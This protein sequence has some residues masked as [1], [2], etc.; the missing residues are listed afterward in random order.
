MAQNRTVMI[1][2]VV[3]TGFAAVSGAAPAPKKKNAKAAPKKALVGPAPLAPADQLRAFNTLSLRR[4]IEDLSATFGGRYPKGAEYLERLAQLEA[5]RTHLLGGQAL[6]TASVLLDAAGQQRVAE[7]LH[8]LETLK[9]EALLSNPLLDFERLLLVKR[10]PKTQQEIQSSQAADKRLWAASGMGR[11]I[12]LPTNHEC[13][14]SIERDGYDNEIAVLSPVRPDGRLTTLYRPADGGYVGEMDLH[15]NADRLLFTQS[16]FTNWKVW[17]I[18]TDGTGLRQVSQAPDDVDCFDACYLPNGKIVFG[19]T[20]SYQAVPCWH[21]LRRVTNLYLMNDDGT[22]MRQICFDQDHNFHPTVMENGQVLYHRWD[23]TGISHIY[24]RQLMVMNPDGMGQRAIYGSNSWY[25]NS[26]YFPKPLPGQPGKILCI[27]SGYHGAHRMGQL[28]I[29]DTR[30]GWYE[31]DGIVQRISGRGDPIN[32][33]VHDILVDQDWPKFLTPYPL[34]DK[35]FLVSCWTDP[36]ADWAIYL[37]D[38]FDNLVPLRVEP[39]YALLE[40]VPVRKTQ[41]PPVIPDK[42]DLSRKDGIVYLHN[43][44]AGPGL[45]GVP[46]GTIKSIRLLAYDFGYPGLAGPDLIGCAGPWEVMRILGTVPLEEDGSAVFRVPANTPVAVQALDAQGRAVQLMRSWYTA[47]PGETISCTGCHESPAESASTQRSLASLRKPRDITPWYGPVRGFD[48]AREVQPVLDR[49]CVACHD[50]REAKPDLRPEEAVP[51]YRGRRLSDLGVQRMHPKMMEA[52]SGV[53]RYTPAYEALIPYIRRVSI[54][55]DVSLL[56]PGEYY[57]RTS[58]LIQLLEKGHAGVRLDAEAWDRLYTWIDLNAPCHG[59]WGEVFPIPD[60]V[61]ARR[62]ELRKLYGGPEDDPE[63]IPNIPRPPVEPLKPPP[64]PAPE[65]VHL[66][67][68]PMTSEIALRR[69]AALGET[70]MTLDLGGG[71]TLRLVQIPPGEFVMGDPEGEPDE[72]PLRRVV[73]AEPFW[74]GTC[75]ITNE[76]FRLFDPS[77]DSRYYQKRHADADDRGL[78][79][80]GPKQPAV[81]VSWNDAMAFCRW[82]SEK[83]GRTFTLPTE[84]QW[85]YACRAGSATPLF[86]GGLDDDFSSWANVGDKAFT[87]RLQPGERQI[88]GGLEH[89]VLEGADLADRR[90][91]DGAI[92]TAP[93][94][95]YR[96]NVW[97]LYDMHGNAAEWTRSTYE[98]SG[99]AASKSSDNE[100]KVVR[101]GSFFDRPKRCRSAFRL[102]YPA[103]QRVFNVGFRVVIENKPTGTTVATARQ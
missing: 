80:D 21:G 37:A 71:V 51:D 78:P 30:R 64:L 66:A 54:E 44:Y 47:M 43:I 74:M 5:Q 92:V 63:I 94:G 89:L 97:G 79:M 67:G 70:G 11:N 91:N 65:P 6:S 10:R 2:L 61:H 41:K 58:E 26:L 34:S 52:T 82:L 8:Q 28:V 38:V 22:G 93:V 20:A 86:Y 42:V 31:A 73:I 102:G 12:G 19:C 55:D 4:A 15:W 87:F 83:T 103:W 85:E 16:D 25:P 75:E 101:G 57:A 77:H 46:K 32:P 90:F 76:Q 13:N 68:W 24:L 29:V 50:G 81:R 23:Y 33:V 7:L 98:L 95:S 48:F 72:Q 69:Q 59:T 40:P 9:R 88:T 60:G 45:K 53:V 18:R 39:G 56:V 1:C 96:P 84:E 14:T 36:Q 27:L 35:Y 49:Y 17:E 3:L 100:N 62:L 99:A